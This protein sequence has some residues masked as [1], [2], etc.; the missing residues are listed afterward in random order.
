VRFA[1]VEMLFALTMAEIGVQTADLV[2]RG[3]GI[4]NALPA[5]AHLLLALTLVATSWVGWTWSLAPGNVR[6]VRY[7]FS[8][9]FVVLL[10]DVLLVIAYFIIVKGVDI[11]R[12]SDARVVIEP[13][14]GNETLWVMI[15]FAGYSTWDFLTKAIMSAPD[16][17]S[18]ARFWPRG[19][20]SLGCLIIAWATW[21]FLGKTTNPTGVVLVDAA[22][23]SLVLCYRAMKQ[24]HWR[25]IAVTGIA[26]L[27]AFIASFR[28]RSQ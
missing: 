10:L 8:W 1:F 15:V 17:D 9:E 7:V 14:A 23:L 13:S 4:Q 12:P 25:W 18:G 3:P 28:F 11:Q 24:G 16:A 20:I 2:T 26:Y 5:Y 27:G 19:S 21:Y 22:L 6:D